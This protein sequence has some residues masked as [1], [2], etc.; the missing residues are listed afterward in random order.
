MKPENDS[1]RDSVLVLGADVSVVKVLSPSALVDSGKL[2]VPSVVVK[3]VGKSSA[4][5]DVWMTIDPAGYADTM[6]V[7]GLKPGVEDTVEFDKW[8]RG[9]PASGTFQVRCSTMYEDD[10]YPTDDTL[11]SFV[12]V[13]HSPKCQLLSPID[14]ADVTAVVDR[15]SG[16][17]DFQWKTKDTV[18]A[19]PFM[20]TLVNPE[21]AREDHVES[22]WTRTL[23]IPADD[24]FPLGKYTW[25]V[26]V[27]INGA[28]RAF[29]GD[30]S[31][32]WLDRSL[33]DTS[34]AFFNYPNPFDNSWEQTTFRFM[35]QFRNSFPAHGYHV[36]L[37][38][39]AL[40]P[41]WQ[42]DTLSNVRPR[43]VYRIPW[44]G[45]DSDERRLASGIYVAQLYCDSDPV[46]RPIRVA[47]WPKK[48]KG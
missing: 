12:L 43:H 14:S 34:F 17:I 5:F 37:R 28:A 7:V 8:P 41:V 4:T 25:W 13:P 9:N 42:S 1:L 27:V 23:S 20:L 24:T 18:I 39:A 26:E 36:V 40:E 35:P 31:T 30:T 45:T 29:T 21:G 32:F 11:T 33:A 47:I 48:R 44:R 19:W 22:T 10:D 2:V 38:N 16:H 3:Y 46:G 15:D 6:P